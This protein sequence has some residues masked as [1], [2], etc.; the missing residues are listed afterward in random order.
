MSFLVIMNQEATVKKDEDLR[1]MSTATFWLGMALIG[2]MQLFG[3]GKEK[4]KSGEKLVKSPKSTTSE[5][6]IT[7]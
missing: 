4:T 5:S 2:L 7:H 1:G 6:G 3:I